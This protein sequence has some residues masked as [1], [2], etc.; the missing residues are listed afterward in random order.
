M[1]AECHF[2]ILNRDDPGNSGF[3]SVP[4]GGNGYLVLDEPP[5]VGDL[6]A[7]AGQTPNLADEDGPLVEAAGVWRVLARCWN[8]ANFGSQAWP[9]GNREPSPVWLDVMLEPAESIFSGAHYDP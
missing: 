9:I 7:L 1:S 6:I 5:L 3:L 2:Y 8:P 4:A